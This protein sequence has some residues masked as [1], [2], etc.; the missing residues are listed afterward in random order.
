MIRKIKVGDILFNDW[1][2]ENN[3]IKKAIVISTNKSK[4]KCV[5][6]VNSKFKTVEYYTNDLIVNE[7]YKYKIIGHV[8]LVKFINN[9][10]Q[11]HT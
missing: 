8:D 7:D 4:T 3:P 5:Y 1:A 2:S 11:E 9:E 10:I 6:V